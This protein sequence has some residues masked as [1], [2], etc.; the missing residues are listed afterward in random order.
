MN[1]MYT[2]KH[3]FIL[4]LLLLSRSVFSQLIFEGKVIDAQTNSGVPFC[5]VA[6]KNSSKGVISNSEGVFRLSDLSPND[7]V[8]IANIGYKRKTI[9]ASHL[10]KNPTVSIERTTNILAEVVIYDKDDYLYQLIETCRKKLNSTNVQ[11]SKVYFTLATE[12]Q[13]QPVELLECY[14]NARFDDNGIKDLH[15]K[16][17]RV[18]LAAYHS[19]FFV[20]L[21]TSKAITFIELLDNN[22]QFPLIPFQLNPKK[23]R[24]NFKLEL[25][26]VFD[27]GTQI[28]HIGFTPLSE[29]NTSF[30]GEIWIEKNTGALTKIK[31]EIAN[32][33]NHPFIALFP[34]GK[35]DNVSMQI[36]KTFGRADSTI[37]GSHIDFNYQL[38]YRVNDSTR[39]VNSKGVMYFYDIGNP[40]N[41]PYF[42]YDSDMDDYKKITSLSYN[43]QFWNS[44][45]GLVYSNK[46]KKDMTYFLRKGLL[47][48]YR[49]DGNLRQGILKNSFF[50]NNYLLWSKNKRIRLKKDGLRHD[51]LSVASSQSFLYERYKI[52]AQLFLDVNEKEDSVTHF[53]ATVFDTYE[54]FYNIKEES[55]TNCF[56]NIYFDLIEIERRTMETTL[57]KNKFSVQQI[58][59]VYK[60]TQ[61]NIEKLELDYF[62]K[63][64]R[65][66]N[67]KALEKWN[68]LVKQNLGI[69]NFEIFGINAT[70]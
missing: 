60:E 20:S 34:N 1:G 44:A 37:S 24:K 11:Q 62:D 32:T 39:V 41:L 55:A 18:G 27:E 31:L 6:I 25:L 68:Y 5:A 64:D 35:I 9:P 45:D 23:L 22:K 50:E 59:S 19:R 54:T 3:K 53:S 10:S 65:G 8:I 36:N 38:N 30:S 2:Y 12:I 49:N 46:M 4:F 28:Y 15:F 26:D 40:F 14:Y 66:K 63:V 13:D 48:N 69:D 43:E 16:N 47:L 70:R 29:K 17:G 51:T 33:Q 61:K 67:I 7:T 57:S 42:S 58:D 52:K 56:I 21:N